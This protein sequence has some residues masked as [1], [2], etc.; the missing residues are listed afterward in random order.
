MMLLV[1]ATLMMTSFLK[2]ATVDAGRPQGRRHFPGDRA[3]RARHGHVCRSP[4]REVPVSAWC[5][6]RWLLDGQ[7]DDA[8]SWKVS[9][10]VHAE[11]GAARPK[12][13]DCRSE[14]TSAGTISKAMGIEVRQ[15][16]DSRMPI[17]LA[18]HR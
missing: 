10:A 1:G 4:Q 9:A 2:L 15:V 18:V 14:S 12:R 3:R 7:S 5:A 17:V 8:G 11:Q 13:A 6:C 16:A